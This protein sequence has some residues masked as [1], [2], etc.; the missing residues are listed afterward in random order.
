M[1]RGVGILVVP[2]GLYLP[3]DADRRNMEGKSMALF[4]IGANAIILESIL[5]SMPRIILHHQR[6]QIFLFMM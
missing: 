2:Q 6:G 3:S 1:V 4:V 5:V